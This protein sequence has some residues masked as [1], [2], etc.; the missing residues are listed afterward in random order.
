MEN[1]R[2]A[3]DGATIVYSARWQGR[4]PTIFAIHAG[5][6]ESQP[7]GTGE[8]TLLAVSPSNELAVQLSSFV[9]YSFYMGELARMPMGGGG[10]RA[11]QGTVQEADWDPKSGELA[12]T[13]VSNSQWRLESPPRKVLYSSRFILHPRFARTGGAIAFAE[14]HGGG[15]GWSLLPDPLDICVIEAAGKMRVL[16]R[17]KRCTGIAWSPKGDEVWFTECLGGSQT[18][19]WAVTLSGRSR[20]IWS[21]QGNVALLDVASDGKALMA[22]VQ[23]QDG[24]AALVP[25]EARERD[26]SVF[27]GSFA[28]DLSPDGK[29]LL[30][31]ERGSG[32]G[33][34]GAIFLCPLDGSPPTRLA[35]GHA[36]SFSA[37]GESVLAA[38]PK[39]PHLLLVPTGTGESRKLDIPGFTSTQMAQFV[40]GAR[41]VVF[42]GIPE[43]RQV[44]IF[45]IDLDKPG[46][47]RE[48]APPGTLEWMGVSP[49]SPDGRSLLTHR[50]IENG[51]LEL[52]QP[53]DGGE[54][55]R[56]PFESQDVPI[57]WTADGKGLYVFKR[58]G[59]PARI[60]RMDVATRKKE[61]V[62][63]FMPADPGG[64]TGF[65]TVTMTPDAKTFAFNYRRR[66][67]ELYL[68]EGLK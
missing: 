68:V 56:I 15:F 37:D 20:R 12:L 14:G 53:L 64:M 5:S 55:T 35:D 41:K 42:Q 24:V 26:L 29:T 62:K 46:P 52:V 63:E 7:L 51:A 8:A 10:A 36:Y 65:M 16:A 18:V 31:N 47:A 38:L 59:L 23:V 1:A 22:T 33:P 57:R 30:V 60:F 43:G 40:P 28:T 61:L 66:L 9:A 32:G 6:P 25:G 54:P 58:Q 34:L 48:L 21:G 27:D 44:G 50:D 13:T 39:D 67:S 2:F 3:P 19:L 17:G 45:E 4:P 49:V 11:I